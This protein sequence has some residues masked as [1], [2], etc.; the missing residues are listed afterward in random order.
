MRL[1]KGRGR[2]RRR[3]RRTKRRRRTRKRKG[4]DRL[5]RKGGETL[6]QEVGTRSLPGMTERMLLKPSKK[7]SWLRESLLVVADAKRTLLAVSYTHL[8]LPTILL[9]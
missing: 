3:K 4:R 1:K 9:V 7:T 5:L 8:T 2:K 6:G